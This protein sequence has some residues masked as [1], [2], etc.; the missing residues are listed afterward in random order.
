MFFLLSVKFIYLIFKDWFTWMSFILMIAFYFL[1]I[2]FKCT[3]NY[4]R[5]EI[6]ILSLWKVKF[7]FLKIIR[8]ESKSVY[9]LIKY[10][11]FIHIH[12]G[13]D[14]PKNSWLPKWPSPAHV[15]YNSQCKK[16]FLHA[17]IQDFKKCSL[18]HCKLRKCVIKKNI[19]WYMSSANQLPL[20]ILN[21]IWTTIIYTITNNML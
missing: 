12:A 21:I 20:Y 16:T 2:A 4:L 13:L 9:M 3:H 1:L 15:L 6:L 17:R 8:K 14:I 5:F 11:N 18:F 7:V 19:L 10:V